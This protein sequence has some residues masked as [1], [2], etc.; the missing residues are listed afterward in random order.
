MVAK[1]HKQFGISF[2]MLL[3]MLVYQEN[4]SNIWYYLCVI[5]MI[6]TAKY[7]AAFPDLDHAWVNVKDKTV[8]N[9]IVNK[10]IHLTGGT[11]R[12]WQTH[13]WDIALLVTF[14]CWQLPR[15]AYLNG[16]VSAVNFEV[17]SIVLMGFC[18][19]WISHL[20]SDM[21]SS[22]GVRLL[23]WMKLRLRFVPKRI[24]KFRFNTG[25]EWEGFIYSLVKK[26]NIVIGFVCFIYPWLSKPENAEKIMSA[27]REIGNRL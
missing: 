10:L 27:L 16:Y 7:G 2:A 18:C 14:G 24:G 11:H 8:P 6:Q 15:W 22:D 20:F 26:I 17:L 25:N 23:C 12:S 1:T 3:S 13:S 19:G 9:W 21:L 5:I 4:I